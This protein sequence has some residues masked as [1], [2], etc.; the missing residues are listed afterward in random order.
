VALTTDEAA[1][2]LHVSAHEVRRL[3]AAGELKGWMKSRIWLID[4]DSV[5]DR[6]RA[7][8]SRGRALAAHTAWAALFESSGERA[9]WL[10][11]HTRSRLRAWLR[12]QDAE[13]LTAACRRRADRH[14]LRVLPTYRERL[15]QLPGVVLGGISDAAR[16]GADLIVTGEAK[17]EI[18]CDELTFVAATK[19]FHLTE[20]SDANVIV[21]IPRWTDGLILTHGELP[22]AVVAVDL[23]EAAD[24]RTHRAGRDLLTQLLLLNVRVA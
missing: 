24:F 9:T 17:S 20:S 3:L 16:A 7:R 15:L 21:R 12:G 11:V 4:E 5:D 10:D 6:S 23:M 18:Y 14:A 2:R 1:H 8:V 19:R 22:A 13:S